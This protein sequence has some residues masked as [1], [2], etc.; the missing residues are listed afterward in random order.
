[1]KEQRRNNKHC[2]G[3]TR[4]VYAVQ[5]NGLSYSKHMKSLIGVGEVASSNLVVPTI[6]L[7]LCFEQLR[8]E[9]ILLFSNP[10]RATLVDAFALEKSL[11]VSLGDYASTESRFRKA[12][13]T[14]ELLET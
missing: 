8:A 2:E 14:L 1:M 5:T 3:F 9:P 7:F 10:T 13:T 4:S 11:S 12:E 6:I